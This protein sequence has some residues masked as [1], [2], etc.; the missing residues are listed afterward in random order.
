MP[1][2][3]RSLAGASNHAPFF[4]LRYRLSG[5]SMVGLTGALHRPHCHGHR[6]VDSAH[7][8]FLS[9]TIEQTTTTKTNKQN[10]RT[11]KQ[12]TNKQTKRLRETAHARLDVFEC[13][14]SSNQQ[15]VVSGESI[16]STAFPA[17]TSKCIAT[18]PS[19]PAAATASDATTATDSSGRGPADG[20]IPQL[21]NLARC[22]PKR[23]QLT[24]KPKRCR[25]LSEKARF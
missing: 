19:R 4:L 1:Y 18:T 21:W 17:T 25:I 23:L 12:K 5:L 15:F 9:A 7:S 3:H 10:K 11:N 14:P 24:P 13:N 2:F 6:P 22:V 8:H 16:Q 20:P